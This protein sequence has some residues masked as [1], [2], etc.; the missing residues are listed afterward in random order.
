VTDS[1]DLWIEM[2]QF[3]TGLADGLWEGLPPPDDA[4]EW[5]GKVSGLIH[6]AS[7][8]A[9]PSDL[10]G[11]ASIVARMQAAIVAAADPPR[12]ID[13][14]HAVVRRRAVESPRHLAARPRAAQHEQGHRARLVGRIVAVKAAALTT[15]VVLGVTAAAAT[16]G[17]VATVVVPA[18]QDRDQ[19]TDVPAVG[20]DQG[21]SSD[22]SESPS[23]SGANTVLD[24]VRHPQTCGRDG[25]GLMG[26]GTNPVATGD[27]AGIATAPGAAES[28]ATGEADGDAGTAPAV[29]PAVAPAETTT[30]TTEPPPT[31]T[32]T[33]EPPP[34]TTTTAPPAPLSDETAGDDA[35]PPPLAAVVA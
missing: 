34:I 11:E 28:D 18:L 21:G 14:R 1:D 6:A 5:Y 3:D 27:P 20:V 25:A 32:T 13:L 2:A 31:T 4:P 16:T 19:P 15:A 22:G 26:E 29:P 9:G 7:A 8:P 33:T 17:I 23:G 10:A 35:E 12:E 24:C 30:T